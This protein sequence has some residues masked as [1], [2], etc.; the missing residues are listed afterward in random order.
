MVVWLVLAG[1]LVLRIFFAWETRQLERGQPSLIDPQMLEN[2]LL[3]SGLT[4]FFFQFLLQAGLFFSVPLYLSVA[5]GLS[6][7]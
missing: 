7:V 6:A 4:S 1:A 5:L 3:R 2:K